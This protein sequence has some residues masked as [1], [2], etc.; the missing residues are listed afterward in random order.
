MRKTTIKKTNY[1][2]YNANGELKYIKQR[3]DYN[4]GSKSFIFCKPDGTPGIKDFER[5]LYNLPAVVKAKAIYIV[6]GEKCAEALIKQGYVAT[7]LDC[8]A[9]SPWKDSYAEYLKDKVIT[10]IPDND[11]QGLNYAKNIKKHIPWA[12]IKEL[13]DTAEK[14]DVFDWLEKGH[15]A[16]EIENLPESKLGD[17]EDNGDNEDKKARYSLDTRQQST[18]L[19]DLIQETKA[20]LF[21]NENNEAFI[22]IPSKQHKE[23][24]DL[25]HTEF[26]L[27]AQRLFYTT[28][29]KA[30]ARESLK[31]AVAILT[32]ETK[33]GNSESY[34]LSTR[35]AR[36]GDDFFYDLTNKDWSAVKINKDGW[37]VVQ[38]VPKLFRRYTHQI[39]QV[40]PQRGGNLSKIF[41]YINMSE[42][43]ALFICWLVSCYVPDI[44]HAMPIFHGEKGAAKSTACVLLKRLIDP[45]A[46]DTLQLTKSERSLIINLQQH[47][48]LPF[49]NVSAINNNTSDTLCRAITGGA[50]Q[51][52]K[53]YTNDEDCIFTFK[54]CIAINGISNVAN[55]SDLLDRA[56]LFE[57]QRVSDSQRKELQDIYSSFEAD[58]PFLLGAIFDT[59]VKAMKIY[60]TVKPDKLTRMADFCRWGYAI[61]EVVF[62]NG[63]VFLQEYKA[64]QATQNLEAINSDCVAYLIVEFMRGKSTWT[65][66]V[67]VFFSEIKEEAEKHGINPNNKNMP[68]APNSLSRRIKAV[69]SNLEAVGITFEISNKRAD[70]NYITLYNK[71]KS[72]LPSYSPQSS[73]IIGS[74]G[75]GDTLIPN[76]D[77]LPPPTKED[78]ENTN[79]E[80]DTEI[81]F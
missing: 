40:A 5:Y 66:R 9:G 71:N 25:N 4:D 30:L 44:P 23:I 24:Y 51:Q 7:T 16:N 2:Y 8:G 74:F 61:S 45:F 75:G 56:I 14:E 59:L 65:R 58:R 39:P 3:T 81:E 12:I 15:N 32:A 77:L 73:N 21:L 49:D 52:R 18:I 22:E 68:Q 69:K 78:S 46:G 62:G 37:T 31:Q 35:V 19:L 1:N 50:V 10:I 60:P 11:S 47:Y 67:S 53:L 63:E 76:G 41:D 54:R 64:N 27:W 26:A 20:E 36:K 43:K 29:Q 34:T 28:T 38:D 55:R 57:L 79:D 70:G 33:F 6:E 13:P 42:Y 17:N 80:N 72:S 48:F